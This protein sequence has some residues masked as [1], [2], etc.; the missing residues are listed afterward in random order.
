VINNKLYGKL[1][2]YKCRIKIMESRKVKYNSINSN[3]LISKYLN[4]LVSNG[5]I[6]GDLL[7]NINQ[8]S[9][10]KSEIKPYFDSVNK[11]TNYQD[12]ILRKYYDVF[13]I[14]D[15]G[16]VSESAASFVLKEEIIKS[17]EEYFK[18]PVRVG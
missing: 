15:L 16:A 3:S 5:V 1:T 17:V 2:K 4:G 18:E 11:L 10:I 8:I 9:Q 7:L 12:R 13:E 6:K 14:S